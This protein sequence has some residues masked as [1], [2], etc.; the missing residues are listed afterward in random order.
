MVDVDA[1][2]WDAS[3]PGL[4]TTAV[5]PRDGVD[6]ESGL[7]A[8]YSVFYRFPIGNFCALSNIGRAEAR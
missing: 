4:L 8:Y 7:Q 3:A 5:V 1:T 2:G 6:P